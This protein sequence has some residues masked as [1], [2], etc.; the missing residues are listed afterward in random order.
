MSA[1]VTPNVSR[2]AAPAAFLAA[3]LL[4][5]CGTKDAPGPL[6]P[7][8]AVGRVRWVNV[9]TDTTRGRVN[10][11]LEGVSFGVNVTN[12]VSCPA[13]LPSPAT[14]LYSPV[15]AGARSLVL[16]R[17]ADT[18]V[19]VATLPFTVA[20]GGDLTVYA[21]GGAGGSAVTAVSIADANTAPADGQVRLRVVHLSPGA[22][23]VDV[24]VTAP[25]ADLAAASPSATNVAV[26]TASAYL[27]LPAGTYQVRAV[28]AGTAA[29]ARAGAVLVSAVSGGN[30]AL[31][32][33]AARTVVV[34]DAVAGGGPVRAFALVDR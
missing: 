30:L 11:T 8:G 22:G 26:G 2:S 6:A 20:D 21:T 24:F 33:G 5:A 17:T 18:S 28:P 34:A 25:G 3:A 7:S 14:A 23:A 32:G 19:T 4:A 27:A 15:L 1:R 31:G 12:G 10:A 29:G 13:C 16:R 9:I